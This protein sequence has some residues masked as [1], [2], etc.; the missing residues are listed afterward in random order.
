MAGTGPA[1]VAGQLGDLKRIVDWTASAW[2]DIQSR[3]PTWRWM[4]SR[5]TI[6]TTAGVDTYAP[7]AFTDSR[8]TGLI[9]RFNHW[10]PED[11]YGV[12]NVYR[13]LTSGG[14]AGQTY[15]VP[16]SWSSYR[17]LY[18]LRTQS[19]G[20]PH[21]VTID[22]QNNLVIGPP[23][24][25]IYTISGEYQMSNQSLTADAD[26]P[27]MPVQYHMLIVYEVMKRYGAYSSAPDVQSRGVEYANRLMRQLEG[28]QLPQI[29]LG[30]CLA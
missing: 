20:I 21:Y 29:M 17:D 12:S 26:I 3:H 5:F 23:P 11:D 13:Y 8:L 16:I 27:E 19:N 9:T 18:R 10:I 22:P 25:G 7:G 15:M 14:I 2:D 24:D 28:N 6:N 1:A 30:D 4:R